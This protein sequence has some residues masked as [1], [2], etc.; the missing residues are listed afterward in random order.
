MSYAI[1]LARRP[2]VGLGYGPT[3]TASA[4]GTVNIGGRGSAKAPP[5]PAPPAPP[6]PAHSY[7]A[8]LGTQANANIQQFK[9]QAQ[10]ARQTAV[11]FAVSIGV[12]PMA[13]DALDS[14]ARGDNPKDIAQKLAVAGATSLVTRIPTQ[15]MATATGL[16]PG[17][18]DAGKAL[19]SGVV[20]G[21]VSLGN[22]AGIVGGAVGFAAGTALCGPICGMV[23]GI[24][25]GAIADAITSL[26]TSKPPV[27]YSKADAT[28]EKMKLHLEKNAQAYLAM[29]M[30][31]DT[32]VRYAAAMAYNR[33][34]ELG[35]RPVDDATLI[36][37]AKTAT[38]F[39]QSNEQFQQEHQ[40]VTISQFV[41]QPAREAFIQA[42][43]S[44]VDGQ[45]PGMWAR[46]AVEAQY[47]LMR[48]RM[49]PANIV[50]L[51]PGNASEWLAAGDDGPL[52]GEVPNNDV[53]GTL[54][55]TFGIM[56]AGN[57]A[58]PAYHLYCHSGPG[59]EGADSFP[60]D[61]DWDRT[62]GLSVPGCRDL[63]IEDE[64]C[65]GHGDHWPGAYNRTDQAVYTARWECSLP[66]HLTW[67]RDVGETTAN[68][69][70][71]V[72]SRSAAI[73]ALKAK[74]AAQQQIVNAVNSASTQV[75]MQAA[76]A[77]ESMAILIGRR[78][79]AALRAS[80][81][82]K[83]AAARRAKS[84]MGGALSPTVIGVI[85]IG[86]GVAG[87]LYYLLRAPKP[88]PA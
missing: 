49:L 11:D 25:G 22:V 8:Q 32:N 83:L 23:G 33:V 44:R 3:A 81:N 24:I 2:Y 40:G 39:S 60:D 29:E 75:Q 61:S 79:Q 37:N 10:A 54:I 46:D 50:S 76:K 21:D 65:R 59:G 5:A 15:Q 72:A 28:L 30:E 73:V 57:P 85:A 13:F 12:P 56:Y 69:W 74:Q 66:K 82:A 88:A 38:G 45:Y 4:S 55:R 53:E 84:F 20:S 16:T 52:L 7:A 6:D 71:R 63:G 34:L 77:A 43:K 58:D 51:L 86:A 68:Q 62:P 48:S 64:Q 36:Q 87:T 1:T 41:V 17:E 70:T 26:F 78:Q 47:T 27:D 42:V 35:L 18:V 31:V 9:T 80:A 19:L 14:L 67:F